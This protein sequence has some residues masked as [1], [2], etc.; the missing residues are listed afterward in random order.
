LRNRQSR[1]QVVRE[2]NNKLF[3]VEEDEN[4]KEGDAHFLQPQIVVQPQVEV[5]A[6]IHRHDEDE[7][8]RH[9]ED[10]IHRDDE[11]E[12]LPAPNA[13]SDAEAETDV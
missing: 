5:L 3:D 10:E 6:E 9:D 12:I 8:H 1:E 4:E 13:F 7:I 2:Y 11:D